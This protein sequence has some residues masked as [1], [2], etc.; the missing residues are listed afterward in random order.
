MIKILVISNTPWDDSNSF[1]S[2]YSNILGGNEHFQIANIY[3]RSGM[4]NTKVCTRFFQITEKSI[5]RNI[6]KKNKIKKIGKEVYIKHKSSAQNDMMLTFGQKHRWSVLYWIRD[7]IW[8]NKKWYSSHL[9]NFIDSFSPDIIFQP[10]YYS[11]YIGEIA[12]YAK[13]KCNIPMLGYISD[14]CYT[15]KQFSLSPFFWIERM[16]KRVYV[17]RLIDKCLILY[18]ITQ[19]QCDEYNKI[20]GNKCKVLCKGCEVNNSFRLP[21][22]I[23]APIQMIYTGNVGGGRWKTLAMIARA[24]DIIN[25]EHT[26]AVLSIYTS[27]K[28]RH[29]QLKQISTPYSRVFGAVSSA[30]VKELQ[31][32]SDIL[33]HVESFSLK[34]RYAARL[35]FSTKIT[36]YLQSGH[37]I[38][39]VG[40]EQTGAIEL[41]KKNNI[42][43]V[44][45]NQS[46]L[47]HDLGELLEKKER[48]LDYG[49]KG[50]EFACDNLNIR[51]I[52]NSI[53]QDIINA[54]N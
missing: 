32:T 52:R 10:V 46:N 23:S 54:L 12:L 13:Q 45:T 22:K 11:T 51:K 1:G 39:A 50:Y 6:F 4:P 20:F 31:S 8:S 5:L 7:F 36:D 17:K 43:C 33:V 37:C 25:A 30:K 27:T 2:S 15:L 3:C 35:S 40:W 24:L 16:I 18:T 26:K 29:S 44:I 14:D 42:A 9:D 38:L 41:L 47:S 34:H 48:I 53:F 21:T 49:R 28:L 19:R